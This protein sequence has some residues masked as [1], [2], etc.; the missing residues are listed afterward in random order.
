MLFVWIGLWT[1]GLLL[2]LTDPKRSTTRWISSIA[3]TGGSGGLSA[4]LGDSIIPYLA[5]HAG[6]TEQTLHIWQLIEIALSKVCYY[7]LPYTFLMFTLV[8]YPQPIPRKLLTAAPYALL[9]PIAVSFAFQPK[10]TAPIPYSYVMLWTTPYILLGVA[11]LAVAAFRERNT[12]LRLNRMLTMIAA[13]PT[14]MFAMFTMYILPA[15]YGV[16]D[17]WRYNLW[18]IIF[19]LAVILVSSLRYG[20]M[21]LQIS[22][23]NQKRDYT[24]RAITSGTAILNHAIKNDVGKIKLFSQKLKMDARASGN[25]SAEADIEVIMSATQHIYEMMS[26]IQGQT[27]EV[28]LQLEEH[29][30]DAIIRDTLSALEPEFSAGQVE[31]AADLRYEKPFVCDSAQLTEVFTNLFTNAAEAMPGGGKLHVKLFETKRTIVAEVQDTGAGMDKKQLKRVFDPFY[32]TK[33]GKKLNFGLGLSYC[34]HVIQ[35]H[36]GRMNIDSKPGKGT[37]VYISFSKRHHALK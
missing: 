8:Y 22:I 31:V 27:Q 20:F 5:A 35:K 7:G 34:Y 25:V 9:A 19:T 14:L 4:V 23:Q 11:L 29:R 13:A 32:T 18:V 12:Y 10:D 17:F 28:D 21:G 36:K 30:L 6:Y 16:Y 37:T 33:A 3:F 1:V 15:Y 24:L 26:R 2:I